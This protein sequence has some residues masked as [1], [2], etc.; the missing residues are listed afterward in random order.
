MPSLGSASGQEGFQ[1]ILAGQMAGWRA[2]KM[3][4]HLTAR[5]NVTIDQ[6]AFAR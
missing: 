6:S 5:H 4:A 2:V 1:A 3:K